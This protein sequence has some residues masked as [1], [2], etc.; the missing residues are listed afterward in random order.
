M[1][2]TQERCVALAQMAAV[3]PTH[4]LVVIGAVAVGHHLGTQFRAT[5]DLDLCVATS[6]AELRPPAAWQKLPTT[7]HRWRTEHG[8][9]IDLLPVDAASLARGFIE[10][11]DRVKLD[12]TGIDLAIQDSRPI[13]HGL[14]S[15]VCVASLRALFLCKAVAWT[16]RPGDRRKDLGDLAEI[17]DRYVELD[18]VRC[19]EEAA[20]P[21]DLDIEERPAF[22]LGHDLAA[23]C[24]P[25]HRERLADFL[26][27]VSAMDQAPYAMMATRWRDYA[28]LERRLDALR[29][30]L[31]RPAS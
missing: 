17:L 23:A 24:A 5:L 6:V 2:W 10:W 4:R 8:M 25:A 15:T 9:P 12:L 13:G 21:L 30:G 7:P 20:I 19:F 22:L 16:D 1:T 29:V 11:P 3:S 31:A 14:P 27:R 26:A 28:A 18:D